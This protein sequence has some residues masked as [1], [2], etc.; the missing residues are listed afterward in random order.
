MKDNFFIPYIK[1]NS[2][3]IDTRWNGKCEYWVFCLDSNH[4]GD[5][6]MSVYKA[7]DLLDNIPEHKQ[8]YS[9]LKSREY[10]KYYSE[11]VR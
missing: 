8:L 7:I 4:A 10:F 6:V 1:D 9:E 2:L 11:I 5:G 3:F